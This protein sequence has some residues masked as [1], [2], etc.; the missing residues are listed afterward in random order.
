MAQQVVHGADLSCNFGAAS[1]KLTVIPVAQLYVGG[2]PAANIMDHKPIV[3]IAP[4]SLCMSPSNPQVAAATAAALG[5][6]TP[7]PCIPITNTRWVPGSSD[8]MIG[9]APALNSTSMCM[10]MWGGQVSVTKYLQP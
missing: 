9:G 7:Q 4:F 8:I 6:L 2:A 5:V 1:S 10:C 3:N